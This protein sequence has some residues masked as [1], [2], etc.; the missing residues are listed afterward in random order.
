[1]PWLVWIKRVVF[2]VVL[3]GLVSAANKATDRWR[4]ETSA[5]NASVLRL[6]EQAASDPDPA[7]AA[8]L[9][10]EADLRA[11]SVP[12][13]ANV[14]WDRVGCASLLYAFGLLPPGIILHQCLN[15]FAVHCSRR[16]ALAA[17]L[18]GH[19]GKYIPG[20]AMVVFLRVDAV[21]PNPDRSQKTAAGVTP[22]DVGE[23]EAE[24]VAS[25]PPRSMKPRP[26]G[27]VVT[28]VFFETLLMMGV[29]GALAGILLWN[30]D[31]PAWIRGGAVLVAIGSAIPVCPPVMRRVI[32]FMAARR[33]LKAAS[34]APADPSSDVADSQR[35]S[36]TSEAA[37]ASAITWKLL[38]GCYL[39]SL[40]SWTLIGLSFAVL[41]TAIP[42]FDPLPSMSELA[43]MATAAI[44][45]GMVIGF[46]S[47]LPGGAG[48][49]EYVTLLVLV[50][51]IGDTH[52]LLAVIAARLMFIVVETLLAGFSTLYLHSLE[53]FPQG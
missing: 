18:L 31:L 53:P 1:M 21:L 34:K 2:L 16:R 39:I 6:R 32:E 11:A 22:N 15:S 51:V 50:P 28:C 9:K 13:L 24:V 14:R 45:L 42:S 36:D 37:G 30:S 38:G 23:S 29:G 19:V 5:L 27:R 40:I 49:R 25:H 8:D 47:L 46:A 44:S 17:Q 52:A 3:I 35:D 7:V 33:R 48:V 10:R 41:V 43:P 20:K 4:S 12:S 26:I